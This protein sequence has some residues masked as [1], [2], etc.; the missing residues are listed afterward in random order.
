[1]MTLHRISLDT[2]PPSLYYNST[3]HV[4]LQG[5]EISVKKYGIT[6]GSICNVNVNM[7]NRTWVSADNRDPTNAKILIDMANLLSSMITAIAMIIQ[8]IA[9][10]CI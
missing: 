5:A 10:T 7:A 3:L 2:T 6:V 1:M 4:W 8:R 9:I